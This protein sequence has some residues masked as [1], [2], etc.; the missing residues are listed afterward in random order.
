MPARQQLSAS[1]S[2]SSSQF[3][4]QPYRRSFDA[5]PAQEVRAPQYPAAVSG[6]P[7]Q[8]SSNLTQPHYYPPYPHN[9]QPASAPAP[10]PAPTAHHHHHHHHH[11]SSIPTGLPVEHWYPEPALDSPYA[12]ATSA[13]E[14]THHTSPMT[15]HNYH[16][17]LTLADTGYQCLLPAHDNP[18]LDLDHYHTFF[19]SPPAQ[20]APTSIPV[21]PTHSNPASISPSV[22][23]AEYPSGVLA[24]YSLS[25][26]P[27]HDHSILLMT[28]LHD[29]LF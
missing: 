27:A 8:Y 2:A 17:N 26:P 24:E 15:S 20:L 29:S 25:L 1:A 28:T 11:P 14:S 23:P 9:P 5:D 13:P 19:S 7:H 12:S 4:P 22:S 18:L 3:S 6:Y 16:P 21:S 10:A